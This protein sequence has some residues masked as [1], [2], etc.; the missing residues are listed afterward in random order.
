MVNLHHAAVLSID[1]EMK[2]STSCHLSLLRYVIHI[3]KD[4]CTCVDWG[5]E[6]YSKFHFKLTL[7]IYKYTLR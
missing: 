6:M 4:I 3:N 1:M 2:L 5:D 7:F